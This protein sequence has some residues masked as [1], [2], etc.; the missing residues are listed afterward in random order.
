MWTNRVRTVDRALLFCALQADFADFSVVC[1]VGLV[2]PRPRFGLLS[3]GEAVRDEP[4]Q[5]I[6]MRAPE[7]TVVVPNGSHYRDS[8]YKYVTLRNAIYFH[9]HPARGLAYPV[10][11]HLRWRSGRCAGCTVI[12]VQ[13]RY[14]RLLVTTW[15]VSL[16]YTGDG[17]PGTRDGASGTTGYGKPSTRDGKPGTRDGASGT[18]GTS[19]KLSA[20]VYLPIAFHAAQKFSWNPRLGRRRAPLTERD[21]AARV[22]QGGMSRSTC[23]CFS[24]PE[25][26][27]A[28][29]RVNWACAVVKIA[30][31][32]DRLG[33]RTDK[34]Y[35]SSTHWPEQG[36]GIREYHRSKRSHR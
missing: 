32:T 25:I 35:S 33:W 19:Y 5:Y 15:T 31:W 4:A 36:G 30:T 23:H 10:C 3:R 2:Y 18:T 34:H 12:H 22:L 29:H 6:S 16:V 17:K 1:Y 21:G 11:T 20:E 8:Q 13:G 28:W 7:T 24:G 27:A 14:I 26:N 9:M